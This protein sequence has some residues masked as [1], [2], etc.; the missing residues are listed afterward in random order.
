[1]GGL[2]IDTSAVV[3]MAIGEPMA[4]ACYRAISDA[5]T[6]V[7]SA[8]TYAEC[9]TVSF[10]KGDSAIRAVLALAS[11]IIVTVDQA[12][13]ETMRRAYA[14]WGKGI[15]LAKLNIFDCFAYALAKER[16]LPLL[17]IGNDFAQTDVRSVL[18]LP[19]A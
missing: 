3:A 13:C 8:A 15:H 5:D 18:P 14:K 1:M 12:A 10:S 11:P 9:L 6:V 19:A 2:V 16:D 17:F 4:I 7:M